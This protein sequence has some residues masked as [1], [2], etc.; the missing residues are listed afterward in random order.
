MLLLSTKTLDIKYDN[1]EIFTNM[2]YGATAMNDHEE[3]VLQDLE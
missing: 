3:R 1:V 2:F